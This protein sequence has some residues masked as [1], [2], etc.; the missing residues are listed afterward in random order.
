MPK[1]SL[2]PLLRITLGLVLLTLSL[3]LIGEVLGLV[4]NEEKAQLDYRKSISESLAVQLSSSLSQND[5]EE[6]NWLVHTI[7]KR[8]DTIR[9]IGLKEYN[10]EL[11]I[12][13][14]KHKSYWKLTEDERS[15][16][17]QINVP[18]YANQK[19]WGTLQVDFK[20]EHVNW[21]TFFKEPTLLSMILFLLVFAPLLYWVFLKR[22]LS[23]LDPSS[24]V[25]E[26]VRSAFDVLTEGLIM[27]DTSE[28]I[29]LVNTAFEKT[30]GLSSKELIG[31][32]ISSLSW[33]L[34]DDTLGLQNPVYP[35]SMLFQ[36]KEVPPLSPIKL[37][38]AYQETLTFEINIAPIKAP[39]QSIKGA[40]VTIDD[41]TEIEK[42]N[43]ELARIL[44]K[45]EA[46]QEEIERQN[47]E[48]IELATKDPLTHLL[49][50]RSLFE[51]M[52]NL[53]IQA[54][55]QNG[56]VSCLMLDIDH[57]KSVNDN[58]G[59]AAGDIVIKAF[60]DIISQT[61][62]D[63]DVV[64]RYGGEEFVVALPG[65]KEEEAA[66]IADEIRI[67]IMQRS[68]KEISDELKVT[69]S[70]GV[71]STINNMWES[72]KMVDLADQAY[73]VA[74]TSGRN[75]VVCY[76]QMD[77]DH[78]GEH[79]EPEIEVDN[80]QDTLAKEEPLS[81][82]IIPETVV[83]DSNNEA[84][85]IA[86][87]TI[88][89][90]LSQ[91]IRTVNRHQS[92]LVVLSIY[93]DTLQLVNNTFGHG[94]TQKLK[95]IAQ[96]RLLEIFRPSDTVIP[97]NNA[98]HNMSLSP[99]QDGSFIVI[100]T[101][102][103]EATI[104]TWVLQRMFKALAKPIE[105]DGHEIIMTANVGGSI[106]TSGD[107]GE[108]D[109]LT[110]SKIALQQAIEEGR[111]T[112]CFYNK[113]MN[114]L[115]KQQ[116]YIESQLALA[117]DR[118]EFH[119][120]YQPIINMHSQKIE[121]VEALLRW[122]HPELG[123]VPPENFIKIAEH[124]GLIS[125]IGTWVTQHAVRQLKQWHNSGHTNLL[126]SINLSAVQFN[127]NDLAEEIIDC[128]G[129]E[130]VDPSSIVFEITETSLIKRLD[131]MIATVNALHQAGCKIAIDDFGT[132]YSS[133]SYLQRLPISYLKIDRSVL[134]NFP[135]NIHDV[136]IVSGL[137]GLSH[138]LDIRV[139]AEGVEDETQLV[140]LNDLRCD[141]VQGF[142]LS[143]PQKARDLTK[144]LDSDTIRRLLYKI[145]KEDTLIHENSPTLS[146]VLNPFE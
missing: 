14:D 24:V 5:T 58:L 95:A 122:K 131:N 98:L 52:D 16:L 7:V 15:N 125:P 6:L 87:S 23:E 114:K 43:T 34:Q 4:P 113:T 108:E 121:K 88:L 62:R 101:D 89:D 118:N 64:G 136:S 92:N 142:L 28:R 76:S 42:K 44:T 51:N 146:Q 102:I 82:E 19:R 140:A 80:T 9:S 106:Y 104:T 103:E 10:E 90:R 25:P 11:V 48:L 110:H 70:F 81:P 45:L 31:K 53:L 79:E 112:F 22:V 107:E 21:K 135:H 1:F 27:L 2:S 138:N 29:I 77:Q 33:E 68:F 141:E 86:H 127:Q 41:V 74:K 54:K 61:I 129:N 133:L 130:A 96:T 8:N 35:W 139:I 26:R 67:G 71:A 69:S 116:L 99:A 126:M 50:R 93:I 56:V 73:Y 59:H 20:P 119:I 39:D 55:E 111:G 123:Q 72:T 85:G 134:E 143:R 100:L 46:S 83:S 124:S 94:F 145:K 13:T 38:T 84:Y 120:E 60:A 66:K 3:I 117:I 17:N 30:S 40:I 91:A 128:I 137:I 63:I 144:F 32:N 97:D 49:N 47:L 109:L 18:I 65:L 105:I 78:T 57:F 115:S 36:T 37:K 75:R 132:G 12:E